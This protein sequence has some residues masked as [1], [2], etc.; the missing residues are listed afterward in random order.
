MPR[1]PK[2]ERARTPVVPNRS[3]V[4]KQ[5]SLQSFKTRRFGFDTDG[6]TKPELFFI[7]LFTFLVRCIK[8]GSRYQKK[9]MLVEILE[10]GANAKRFIPAM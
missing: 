10:Y 1:T 8:N 6:K 2:L 5:S 7:K 9:L 4:L 3:D